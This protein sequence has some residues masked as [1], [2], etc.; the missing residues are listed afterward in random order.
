MDVNEA[1]ATTK[2]WPKRLRRR[3]AVRYLADE[4]GIQLS[5]KTLR[6]RHSQGT[7]PRGEY[8]GSW[9]YTTPSWLDA[10][11]T[12]GVSDEPANRR[13]AA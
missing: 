2:Q 8:F 11:V 10:W 5:E 1:T 3:E 4:H 13:E 6:N 12:D 7:G 9:F